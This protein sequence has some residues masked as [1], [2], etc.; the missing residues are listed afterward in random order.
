V[1]YVNRELPPDA[2]VLFLWEPRSYHCQIECRPDA[3][4]DR[5]LHTTHVYGHDAA[6]IADAWRADGVTHVLLCRTGYEA[7]A[8]A[9]FDPVTE[10]DRAALTTLLSTEMVAV[11][12]LGG[13]Y[14]LYAFPPEG[15]R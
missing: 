13:V 5:W 10:A 14:E 6:T 8:A 11:D 7:I 15:G 2:V 12:D 4:L 9:G 1:D 3:L